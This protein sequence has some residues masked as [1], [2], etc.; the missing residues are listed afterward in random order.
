LLI[1]PGSI[2]LELE[3]STGKKYSVHQPVTGGWN[4]LSF[5]FSDDAAINAELVIYDGDGIATNTDDN[6]QVIGWPFNW[7]K[8]NIR[9]D[10][11]G[12]TNNG[13]AV[14]FYYFDDITFPDATIVLPPEVVPDA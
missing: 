6:G 12:E 8:I 1:K 11:E 7:S 13:D 2:T 9:P 14:R 3:T 5:D 4:S 10:A